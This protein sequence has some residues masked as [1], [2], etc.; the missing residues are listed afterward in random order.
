MK[1]FKFFINVDHCIPEDKYEFFFYKN[2]ASVRPCLKVYWGSTSDKKRPYGNVEAV[3]I[4]AYIQRY[5]FSIKGYQIVYAMKINESDFSWKDSFLSKLF[6]ID[7]SLKQ[8]GILDEERENIYCFVSIFVFYEL[9]HRNE[10][11]DYLLDR[12]KN[13]CHL[14]YEMIKNKEIKPN[15]S[16]VYFL[17]HLNRYKENISESDLIHYIEERYLDKYFIK[18]LFFDKN[19]SS[20]RTNRIF[21]LIEY[22]NTVVDLNDSNSAA[23]DY[24]NK[25]RDI[26]NEI[27][28]IDDEKISNEYRIKLRHY[29]SRLLQYID[30]MNNGLCPGEDLTDAKPIPKWDKNDLDDLVIAQDD[31][32]FDSPDRTIDGFIAHMASDKLLESRWSKA[33]NDL[34]NF[35]NDMDKKLHEYEDRLRQAYLFVLQDRKN[36]GKRKSTYLS[37]EETSVEINSLTSSREQL[38]RELNESLVAPKVLS[39]NRQKLE[40][41]IKKENDIIEFYIECIVSTTV[42][43]YFKLLAFLMLLIALFYTMLQPSA[44][45]GAYKLPAAIYL[46]SVLI[47]MSFAWGIPGRYFRSKI[48][49]RLKALKKSLSDQIQGYVDN[50]EKIKKYVNISNQLDYVERQI[51]IRQMALAD[52][53]RRENARRFYYTKAVEHCKKLEYFYDLISTEQKNTAETEHQNTT[54]Y[55]SITGDGPVDDYVDCRLFWP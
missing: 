47:I 45:F 49:R 21:R 52:D 22:V 40:D 28:D 1:D 50:A 5:P 48:E 6:D 9:I 51:E 35:A 37:N 36:T 13:E 25:S 27:A 11:T 41:R 4:S 7:Y 23:I 42:S 24:Y 19:R 31:L 18:G 3:D 30:D 46:F 39:E 44:F 2:C 26:W 54:W 15:P 16:L 32:D 55:P 12:I 8:V 20:E 10:Q 38:L 34:L 14:L 53:K 33:Y 17:E 43:S 29:N